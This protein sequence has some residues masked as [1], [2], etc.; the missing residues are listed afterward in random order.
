MSALPTETFLQAHSWICA[1][2]YTLYSYSKEGKK[3]PELNKNRLIL[4]KLHLPL[5]KNHARILQNQKLWTEH[6]PDEGWLLRVLMLL[7]K[8]SE[9]NILKRILKNL[10]F[11][12]TLLLKFRTTFSSLYPGQGSTALQMFISSVVLVLEYAGMFIRNIQ[13]YE[14]LL[15]E[16][17]FFKILFSLISKAYSRIC[18]IKVSIIYESD[19]FSK[20]YTNTIHTAR[21]G[22]CSLH[23]VQQ[24]LLVLCTDLSVKSSDVADSFLWCSEITTVQFLLSEV[25][26]LSIIG[27]S[28]GNGFNS[29]H[30]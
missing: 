2:T 10:W 5:E 7:F 30:Y 23:P 26:K 16:T 14:R 22:S 9:Q 8:L 19:N 27:L 4:G 24:Q 28:G 3:E 11:V 18:F 20:T 13:I 25:S 12:N 1:I 21:L 17:S 6:C 29:F 15:L